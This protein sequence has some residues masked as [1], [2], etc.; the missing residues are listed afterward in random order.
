LNVVQPSK[1]EAIGRRERNRLAR[2]RSYLDTALHLATTEGLA[3]VTMQRLADELDCA[4]GTVYTYFPSKGALVAEVQ[5]EA[6]DRLAASYLVLVG[7]LD[8]RLPASEPV[9]VA[10]L[11]HVLAVARF[12]ID[13]DITYPEETRLLQILMSATEPAM[14]DADATRV[15]PSAMRL[16]GYAHDRIVAAVD[17][18]SLAAGDAS[19]R[20]VTLAAAVSGV[21]QVGRLARW[22]AELL[23]GHRLANAFVDD[24]LTGWGAEVGAL[25]AADA[26]VVALRATG[27]LARPIATTTGDRP[28]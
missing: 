26:H 22:D 20:T 8:A 23:D 19:D 1:P 3:A 18:G 27:P 14:P 25:A 12:F 9:E 17:A 24:L 2:H 21:L 6:I 7:E 13:A 4:V 5:R 15:V 16:L 28:A 10:T 11:T